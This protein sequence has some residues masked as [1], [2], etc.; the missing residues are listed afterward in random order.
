MDLVHN[1]VII[2]ESP[3]A[4]FIVHFVFVKIVLC[5]H[6]PMLKGLSFLGVSQDLAVSQTGYITSQRSD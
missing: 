3:S 6:Y 4:Q 1:D 2:W 5:R